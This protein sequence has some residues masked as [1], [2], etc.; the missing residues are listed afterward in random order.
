[1]ERAKFDRYVSLA[2][3]REFVAFISATV[4]IVS[5][6]RS[7]KACRDPADDKFLDVA[8]NGGAECVVTGDT[9]L[10][11]LHPFEGIAIVTPADFLARVSG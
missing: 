6:R 10:R 5:I 1:M 4:R 11:A 7:V 8:V 3:R 2:S 9:D